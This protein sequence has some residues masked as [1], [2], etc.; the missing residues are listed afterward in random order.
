MWCKQMF[1]NPSLSLEESVC[2]LYLSSFHCLG[3]KYL[4]LSMQMLWCIL[5][6]SGVKSLSFLTLHWSPPEA[7]AAKNHRCDLAG[8]QIPF[9]ILISKKKYGFTASLGHTNPLEMTT[10]IVSLKNIV[11]LMHL[12]H[13][14]PQK[15]TL[16][17]PLT[18]FSSSGFCETCISWTRFHPVWVQTRFQHGNPEKW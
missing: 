2:A 15:D 4:L 6:H 7:E 13:T 10:V 5:V 12:T 9:W 14:L 18:P 17:R 8:K 1:C 3:L 11:S 16:S